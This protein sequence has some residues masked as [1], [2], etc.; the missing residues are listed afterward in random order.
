MRHVIYMLMGFSVVT[1]IVSFSL[2]VTFTMVK[3]YLMQPK[4]YKGL[5][6]TYG[7]LNLLL[8]FTIWSIPLPTIYTILHNLSTRKKI[9]L[10]L[11]FALGMMSLCSSILRVSLWKYAATLGGDPTYNAPILYVLY[12]S[13]VSLAI[14]CVSVAAL[15][16]LV[17]KVTK[18]FNRLRG[19][20]STKNQSNSTGY[21]YRA[22]PGPAQ[23]KGF[24]SSGSRSI[25]NKDGF[26]TLDEELVEWR[27]V[28]F[29]IT[30][31]DPVLD[32]QPQVRTPTPTPTFGAFQHPSGSSGEK[33]KT[34][35][36]D[37]CQGAHSRPAC[38]ALSSP[39]GMVSLADANTTN[40]TTSYPSPP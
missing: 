31:P 22:S 9:L 14:N 8:D 12:I 1:H 37:A 13:E 16:P 36:I 4:Y 18:G 29:D 15:R 17:V 25:G 5:W 19:K 23:L 30:T 28:A 2:H 3:S 26:T 33:L 27:D 24:G 40:S 35:N 21:G 7:T 39:G 32:T 20:P 11:E 6:F 34:T 38:D 10:V